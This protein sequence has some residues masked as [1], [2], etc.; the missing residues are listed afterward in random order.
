MMAAAKPGSSA[1]QTYASLAVESWVRAGDGAA[2]LK[3]LEQEKITSDVFWKAQA[4]MLVGDLESAE[5]LLTDHLR[6]DST[7]GRDRLLLARVSLALGNTAQARELLE[8]LRESRETE[9]AD[10]A[11]LIWDELQVRS[12][13]ISAAVQHLT[14][15]KTANVPEALLLQA[16]GLVELAKHAEAQALLRTLL[17]LKN[18]GERVHH[19]ASL[20]L[21]DSLM[22]QGAQAKAAEVLVQFLDNTATSE[23]WSQAFD[24]LARCLNSAEKSALPPDATLRWISEGNAAQKVVLPEKAT[25]STFQGH[26]MLL[27]S[28]WLLHQKRSLEALGLLEAMIQ[29]HQGHPQSDEAMRLA[30][31][32]Y[33]AQ[34]EE[35]R[36]T[37]LTDL[38][39]GRFGSS[40]SSM[41]ESVSASTAFTRGDFT[42]AVKLFQTAGNLAITLAERR[43]ALYNAAICA[44]RAGEM[45]LY[46]SLLG[47]LQVVSADAVV[48]SKDGAVDLEL[49]AALDRAAKGRPE[50]EAELLAFIKEQGYHP[51][52]VE[53]WLALA[54]LSLIRVPANFDLTE[55]ALKSA[56]SAPELTEKQRQRITITRLWQMDRQGRL[57]SVTEVGA[58]F[59]KNTPESEHAALV[60]MKVADAYFR[61]ENFAAARTEFELVAKNHPSSVFADSALYFAGLSALSMMSDEGRETAISQWQEIAERGGP[62]SIPA[63]QQQ[64]LAKRRGGQEIE[65]LKLIDALLKEKNLAEELQRS[66]ACEKAEILMLLGKTDAAQLP[67]AITVL[68]GVLLED[69]ISYKWRAR[70]G[71]T[72]AVALNSSGSHAEA[73]EACHDVVQSIGFSGPSDPSEFRW[74]YRAGFFGM[75]LLETTKQWE[76]AARM[77][78]RLG[79]SKGDRAGEAKERATKIRLEHFLWDGK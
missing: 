32:T 42:Q 68:R 64:A 69:D 71:Y 59:L 35:A 46:Q 5:K 40:G 38:W 36:V 78:E 63:R 56:E 19:Q 21:A 45:P 49:D 1:R 20:L 79:D 24:T 75:D 57:K 33:S 50:A 2:A 67:P 77:A 3:I 13:N 10:K 30:L 74:F 66:L 16:E 34:K 12:G 26:A 53:A 9:I 43:S 31:E 44:L 23:L 58:E 51:R 29:I 52:S 17:S 15:P 47:Q 27:I 14:L 18:G 8:P 48:P 25:T 54:D 39:R 70:A 4:Q 65:A 28:R 22:Q 61:L 76:A 55:R 41:V 72:L 73:L 11:L 7:L 60:R 37:A 62:L 6:A